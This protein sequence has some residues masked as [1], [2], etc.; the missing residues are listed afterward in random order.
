[1]ATVAVGAVVG[2]PTDPAVF[3]L[4]GLDAL[5]DPAVSVNVVEVEVPTSWNGPVGAV[6]SPVPVIAAAGI[7]D[8]SS[9]AAFRLWAAA[10]VPPTPR[11]TPVSVV[12]VK[13]VKLIC[14]ASMTMIPPEE[15]NPAAE[16]SCTVEVFVLVIVPASVVLGTDASVTAEPCT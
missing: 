14:S 2:L 6:V 3:V 8:T 4:A 5:G 1:M 15:G 7:V 9:T 13:P 11:I 10:V 16:P 12:P